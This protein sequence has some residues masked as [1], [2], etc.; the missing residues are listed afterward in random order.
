[1]A[2]KKTAP[3]VSP[4]TRTR[5]IKINGVEK[6]LEFNFISYMAF[7]GATGISLVKGVKFGDLD[8][9]EMLA[10]L[11]AGLLPHDRDLDIDKLAMSLNAADFDAVYPDVIEMCKASFPPPS[12]EQ[13]E[14]PTKPIA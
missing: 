11:Y 6:T 7:H 1:M 13:D 5:K 2:R 14:N 4:T 9:A 12:E 8:A 3:T 10:L